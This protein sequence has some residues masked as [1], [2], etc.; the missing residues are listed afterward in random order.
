MSDTYSSFRKNK[1]TGLYKQRKGP[2]W[3]RIIEKLKK[4][5]DPTIQRAYVLCDEKLYKRNFV[6]KGNFYRLCVSLESREKV[7]SACHSSETAGHLGVRKTREGVLSRHFWSSVREDVARYVR[8]CLQCQTRKQ[9]FPHVQM[10]RQYVRVFGP[11][12]TVGV[13]ILGPFLR[14]NGGN[15]YV[16]LA[17]DYLTK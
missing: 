4:G 12:E 16:I 3:S 11:F 13:D 5:E 15:K 14:S 6:N 8:T 17:V 9:R 7:L 10:P 2:K 1:W